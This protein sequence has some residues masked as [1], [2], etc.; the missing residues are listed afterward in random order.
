M[1]RQLC[2]KT[3]YLDRFEQEQIRNR[4]H[5]LLK[6]PWGLSE[7]ERLDEAA[8]FMPAPQAPSWRAEYRVAFASVRS[9][10]GRQLGRPGLWG[11]PDARCFPGKLNEELF[12]A[13]VGH[14]LGAL[15]QYGIVER[16]EVSGL[17]IGWR[18]NSAALWWVSGESRVKAASDLRITENVFFQSL[19]RN[20]AASLKAGDRLLHRLEAREHT[21]Q[22]DAEAR[23]EREERFREAELPVLFVRRPWS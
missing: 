21:A 12:E 17:G 18:V 19:Y 7:D 13:M 5:N 3:R 23:E 14:L 4:S 8:V 16:V 11:G 9:R 22:V 1:R 10:L 20:V 2:I 6:E 15:E